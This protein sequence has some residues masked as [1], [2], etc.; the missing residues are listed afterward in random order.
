MNK[1][2]TV[3]ANQI[4]SPSAAGEKIIFR[5]T[6]AA[7]TA[8]LALAGIVGVSNTSESNALTGKLE[9]HTA[10]LFKSLLS[11]LLDATQLG[12]INVYGQGTPGIGTIRLT[13]N[14][15]NNDTILIGPTGFERTYTYK[16]TL[17]GAAYEIHRDAADA[18]VTAA[19]VNKA[20]NA[21]SGIGTDYGTGTAANAYATSTVSGDILTI[22]DKIA[23]IRLLAWNIS[24]TGSAHSIVQPFGGTTGRLLASIAIGDLLR[25]NAL[26]LGTED[27][28]SDTLPALLAPVTDPIFL[29]GK[30]CALRIKAGAAPTGAVPVK[31]QHSTDKI[32]WIDGADTPADLDANTQIL[33][34]SDQPF[35]YIRLNFWDGNTNVSAMAV[36]AR[37]IYPG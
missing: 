18:T 20:I 29:N 7:D 16:T 2:F 23:I 3:A 21:G 14:P 24:Q 33:H 5:S 19:N 34:P 25:M 12:V 22:T 26:T 27:L 4:T 8:N 17:T 36:D 13:T 6:N 37:V 35:E 15:A 28:G 9:V 11:I 32:N 31:Y 1:L 10:A 30:I